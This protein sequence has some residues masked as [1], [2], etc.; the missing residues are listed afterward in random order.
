MLTYGNIK[1][2]K[3][4]ACFG[5]AAGRLGSCPKDCDGCYALKIERLRPAVKLHRRRNYVLA[6]DPEFRNLMID[7]IRQSRAKFDYVR[8]HEGGEFFSH[9]YV[10]A[11][12]LIAKAVP[13]KTFYAYTIW[14]GDEWG[15]DRLR[16]LPNFILI[17]SIMDDGKKNYGSLKEI[18]TRGYLGNLCR[19]A[20]GECGKSCTYCMTNLAERMPPVFLKH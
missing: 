16:A 12:E 14:P 20:K 9:D 5:L 8:V 2:S 6:Q 15:L 11:W 3:N 18:E 1:L 7:E 17:R 4:V 10:R 19:A 13:G